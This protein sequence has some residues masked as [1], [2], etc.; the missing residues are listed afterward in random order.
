MTKKA[1]DK[2]VTVKIGTEGK[3]L[4]ILPKGTQVEMIEKDVNY[5]LDVE[6]R[7]LKQQKILGEV[8]AKAESK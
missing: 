5:C 8:L 6:K 7:Y 3:S 4:K 2:M 1:T